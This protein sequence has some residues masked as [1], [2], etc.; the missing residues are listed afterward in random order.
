MFCRRF[1]NTAKLNTFWQPMKRKENI[2]KNNRDQEK[3]IQKLE[4]VATSTFSKTI[5]KGPEMSSG[6]WILWK[7]AV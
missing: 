5:I 2:D 1:T 7:H 4:N 6:L 3:K